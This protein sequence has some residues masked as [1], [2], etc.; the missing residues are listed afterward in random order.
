[1]KVY[2]SN[3]IFF[4]TRC[5][6]E[7]MKLDLVKNGPV[8]VAFQVYSDFMFY[9]S[10]IYHHTG[11]GAK[12]NPFH[13]V[14]HGVLITGYGIDNATGEKFWTVKNSWGTTW[15]EQGYFRIRRGTN[16]CNIESMAVTAIPI[17]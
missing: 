2:F 10:G 17:P 11:I 4:L 5:N 14:N 13:D 15:G 7:L 6:E 3:L 16:E 1:M 9:Q 8:T 12:F